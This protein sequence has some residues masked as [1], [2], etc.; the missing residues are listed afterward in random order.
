MTFFPITLGSSIIEIAKLLK[1]YKYT[2]TSFSDAITPSTLAQSRSKLRPYNGGPSK[3]KQKASLENVSY[4]DD[5]KTIHSRALSCI[6]FYIKHANTCSLIDAW[7]IGKRLDHIMQH[8]EMDEWKTSND[9]NTN[10]S[11]KESKLEKLEVLIRILKNTTD[12]DTYYPKKKL[13]IWYEL[14]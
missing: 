3:G 10:N 2:G 5:G 11:I 9:T 6:T 14:I 13:I 4:P 1:K 12:I 7:P 8:L